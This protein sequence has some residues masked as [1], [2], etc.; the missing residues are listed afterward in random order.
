MTNRDTGQGAKRRSILAAAEKV[1]EAHG[2]AA[3]TVDA[4]AAEAGVAKGSVYNYFRS[5]QELFTAVFDEAFAEDEAAVDRL[6]AADLSAGQ[7]LAE[8]LNHWYGRMTHYRRV[9]ALILESWAT[10]ARQEP[11]GQMNHGFRQAYQ[12][13]KQRM[14]SIVS[15]GI[16]SGEFGTDMDPAAASSLIL[17]AL[18]GL[19]VHVIMDVGV[20]IDEAFLAA[21]KQ[22]LT[23]A[24]AAGPQR[25]DANRPEV[26]ADE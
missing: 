19:T 17:G 12:R 26:F 9:G 1:F 11:G 2:Y 21:L 14:G 22:G 5:K 23:S 13:R 7:K 3:A 16:E 20:E 25:R 6:L 4:V 18:N 10:A 8:Y 15:Q 24:L